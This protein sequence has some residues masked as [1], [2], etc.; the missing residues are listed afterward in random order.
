MLA[1]GLYASLLALVSLVQ[2]APVLQEHNDIVS[3][4]IGSTDAELESRYI[5]TQHASEAS[6]ES[7]AAELESRYIYTQ[8]ASEASEG[9]DAAELDS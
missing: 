7:D 1:R 9:S 8:Q 2:A 3:R 6:E 4:G 5:Y